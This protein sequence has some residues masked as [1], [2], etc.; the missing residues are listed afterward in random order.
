MP[1]PRFQPLG[2]GR[3]LAPFDHADWL[4]EIKFDG[5]RTI[6][7]VEHGRCQLFSRNGNEFKSFRSLN[8]SIGA[9]LKDRSAVIDGEIVVLD[10]EGKPQFYEPFFRRGEPRLCAFDLLWCDGQELRYG[11]VDRTQAKASRTPT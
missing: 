1:L 6:A 4:F 9:V 8:Q 5:F 3:R 11:T 2:V 10:D 7:Y